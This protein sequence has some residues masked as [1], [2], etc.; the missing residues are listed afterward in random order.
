MS[1]W[2]TTHFYYQCQVHHIMET[3]NTF[4]RTD[5][6]SPKDPATPASSHTTLSPPSPSLFFRLSPELRNQIYQHVHASSVIKI[7]TDI[8]GLPLTCKQIY[9]ECT[10]LIYASTAFYIEDWDTLLRWLKRLPPLRRN[11]ITEIWC[12]ADMALPDDPTG[13]V[14]C[15]SVLRRMAHRLENLGLGLGGQDVLRSGT[16]VDEMFNVWSS[17]PVLVWLVVNR[18]CCDWVVSTISQGQSRCGKADEWLCYS[19]KTRLISSDNYPLQMRYEC[20]SWRGC[21]RCL[22]DIRSIPLH[23]R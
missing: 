18:V 4:Q 6:S 11:L 20:G 7:A 9:A 23:L 8:P 16:Q 13:N 12:G 2:H 15:H 5:R 1:H 17:D 3:L 19:F 10:D 22:R 21:M 14:T